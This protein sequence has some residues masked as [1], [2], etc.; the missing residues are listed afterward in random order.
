MELLE[1]VECLG[2]SESCS[3]KMQENTSERKGRRANW[4]NGVGEEK[5]THTQAERK[6][7]SWTE[8]VALPPFSTSP[9]NNYQRT[10]E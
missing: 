9:R 2:E 10:R 3:P 4:G 6:G 1:A 8:M 5:G 7:T